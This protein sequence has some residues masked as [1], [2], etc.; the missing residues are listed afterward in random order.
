MTVHSISPPDQLKTKIVK[1]S[2][3]N[4]A[5][6]KWNDLPV[7]LHTVDTLET[8]KVKAKIWVRENIPI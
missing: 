5:I 8:F 6:K 2:F 4:R 3:I 7:E 1:T